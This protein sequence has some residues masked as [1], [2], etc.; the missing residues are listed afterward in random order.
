MG[1]IPEWFWDHVQET[2]TCW[3][4]TGGKTGLGYGMFVSH[5]QHTYAHRLCWEIVNGP[6]LEGMCI[7]HKCDNPLCVRPDHLA[8]GTQADNMADCRVK[9]RNAW[10][11]KNGLHKATAQQVIEIRQRY[12]AGETQTAMAREYS[13]DQ[14]T[15]SDIVTGKSWKGV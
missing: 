11:E 7:L 9:G 4:W 14:S 3:L 12:A 8:L 13:L 10:G 15:L 5:G 2:D 1:R 6:I